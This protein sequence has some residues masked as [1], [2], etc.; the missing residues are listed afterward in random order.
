M[1]DCGLKWEGGVEID[2]QFCQNLTDKVICQYLAEQVNSTAMPNNLCLR[3]PI[4]SLATIT[5][6]LGEE[7]ILRNHKMM[8][9]TIR[10]SLS[11]CIIIFLIFW[12][13]YLFSKLIASILAPDVYFG[14]KYTLLLI[15]K[16]FIH[17]PLPIRRC[18]ADNIKLE[19]NFTSRVS[20]NV[21]GK[22]ISLF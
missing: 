3:K 9:N 12:L 11:S 4:I 13:E 17:C 2:L 7:L 6:A 22:L 19:Y 20:S 18:W 10:W 8:S 5:H 21:P 16:Y 1:Q 14:Y 15:F